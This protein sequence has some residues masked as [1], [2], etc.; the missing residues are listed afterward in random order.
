MTKPG[1]GGLGT[2]PA[3]APLHRLRSHSC[4]RR[5]SKVSAAQKVQSM[6][7]R[8]MV[9]SQLQT[10]VAKGQ[11][12]SKSAVN[13]HTVSGQV[14][15]A[16]AGG[17]RSAPFKKCSQWSYG[18]WSGHSCKRRWSKVSAA[19]KVTVNGHTVSGQATAANAGGQRS[20]PLKKCSQWSYGQWSGHSC[21]R[22]WSKVSAVQKVQSM[23]KRSV[24]RP[25]C[26]MTQCRR[27]YLCT[28]KGQS[29]VN[30]WSKF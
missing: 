3:V 20:A 21:K 25:Q 2:R 19:Q 28:V 18:Q 29:A 24:V 30:T 26:R 8:S 11:R 23:V 12:R 14:T 13:G 22:R 9:R 7:I 15:A 1:C 5:W 10:Q 6:V 16:N 17:Q 27:G 4:K